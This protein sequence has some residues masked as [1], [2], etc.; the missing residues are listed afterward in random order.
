MIKQNFTTKVYPLKRFKDEYSEVAYAGDMNSNNVIVFIHGA[1]LTYK[2]M[3]MFEPYFREY[4]MIF[5]N[6]PSRGK[7]SDLDRD[8]HTL[9]DYSERIYDV[10]KQVVGEQ[11][12]HELSIVGYSM[13]GMIATRLLKYNTLPITHLIYLHSAAKITPDASMLARLFT[14]N[15]KRDILKDE[16]KA[17]KNLPQYILNK[18]IYAHK[19]N[20]LDLIQYVAPI[21]TII[22][23]ILYTIKTDYL[24]DIDEIKQFPKIMFMSGK[25]DQIIPYTDSQATLEKFKQLGG[26]TK[27]ILYPGIGHIDFPSVLETTS[28]DQIGVVDHIKNWISN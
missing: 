24:P 1:L 9:D 4:K 10:L 19:E 3:T 14:N 13:G 26:E 23:D 16:V 28:K 27:E 8:K 20:A 15:S 11:Q 6:C 17:V 7:S 25:E 18:T 12:I 2:I 21:K 5:V 22:T